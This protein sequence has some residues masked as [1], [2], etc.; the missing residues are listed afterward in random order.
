MMATETDIELLESYLDD[1][2]SPAELDA[3][4]KRLS[5]E[6][7][8]VAAMDDLRG[9]REMRRQFFVACDPEEMSVERLVKSVRQDMN[10]DLV[11]RER[12]RVLGRIGS[13]AACLLVGFFVGHGMHNNAGGL[14]TPVAVNP[15]V[16]QME[17]PQNLLAQVPPTINSGEIARTPVMFDGPNANFTIRPNMKSVMPRNNQLAGYQVHLVDSSGNIVKSFDSLD[18][19]IQ[20]ANDA[21]NPT[22][23]LP[24][25]QGGH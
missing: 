23:G 21:N 17:R 18:Q 25:L 11:W 22:P 1:E 13:L 6:P 24:Q 16:T 20:A 14:V 5:S 2:L 15:H 4:R 12:N 8:L 7:A 10:R 19:A 3:L 9:Q